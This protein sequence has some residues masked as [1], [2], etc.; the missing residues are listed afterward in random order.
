M[1]EIKLIQNKGFRW[2]TNETIFVKGCFFDSD[3]NFYEKENMLNYFSDVK[4]T[5]DFISKISEANGIFTVLIHREDRIMTASDT[6]RIFPLFYTF[7]NK[8]LF[9]SDD[10]VYLKNNLQ[11]RDLNSDSITEF[12]AAAHTLGNKTLLKDIY[13]TQSNEYLIFKDNELSKHGF[14]FSYSTNH[15]NTASYLNLK[16]KAI[17]VFEESFKRLIIS[18]QNR[19]VVLPL[20]GGY[21]S[22]LIAVMLKKHNYKN[23][24]CFTFGKKNNFEVENSKKTAEI[25]GFK[26]IFIEYSSELINNYIE[27]ETFKNYVHYAGKYSSM[28]F[29]Q[30]YFAVNYLK[31]NKLIAESSVFIPGHSGDLLGG[32][33]LIKVVPENLTH[34]KIPKQIVKKKLFFNT[35]STVDKRKIETRIRTLLSSFNPNYQQDISYSVFEDYDIKEKITKFIFNS[36]SVFNFF[37]YEQRFPYW[38]KEMLLLFK[39][40]PF[41]YKKMK[42]LYDDV[43]TNHF[44]KAFNLNFEK[45]IQSSLISV[46]FQKIK[47][48]IK[49]LLPYPFRK[50]FL[51]KNDW[52]NY[53][54]ITE[55][56]ILSA[57]KNNLSIF[58][59]IKKY[60][61]VII[62][63]YLLYIKNSENDV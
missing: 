60:N 61:E 27:T 56:M 18:L 51:V 44:F 30:E 32:S 1:T 42:R 15:I 57:G 58:K 11:I 38:D 8:N 4:T 9:L 47:N 29:L 37:G 14:F 62:R 6:S 28:P 26:W 43:L 23:V 54:K 22:R 40:V 3:N 17:G 49:T 36:T 35:V 5:K 59:N 2:F 16:T 19:P 48:R 53:E 10:I 31:E 39:D 46:Y 45:E 34:S 41:K 13:Q 7:Q 33:Q 24:T 12:T 20:S 50:R 25:L 52:K 63:W 21:D 55:Q